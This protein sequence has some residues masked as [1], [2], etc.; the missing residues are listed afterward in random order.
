PLCVRVSE[1]IRDKSI[2]FEP[3]TKADERKPSL[4][5][6]EDDEFVA[7]DY[8]LALEAVG[9]S[10]CVVHSV[11]EAW[12]QAE[13]HRQFAAAVLDIRMPWS[14]LFGRRESSGGQRTGLILAQELVN[15]LP[16]AAFFALTNSNDA[17][18]AEWFSPYEERDFKFCRKSD[19]SPHRFAKMVK[20]KV[21]KLMN[22]QMG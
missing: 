18:V 4:L 2:D 11:E 22:T 8:A 10:V 7:E 1:K 19:Y 9:F 6:V 12:L 21:H 3:F 14:D 20:R 13:N 16:D 5:L 15:H 17:F